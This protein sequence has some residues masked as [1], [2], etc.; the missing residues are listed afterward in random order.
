FRKR[1]N[2]SAVNRYSS[3]QFILFEQRH[4]EVRPYPFL[5]VRFGY[6]ALGVGEHVRN[7]DGP[8]FK[9]YSTQC[10]LSPGW[11][12]RVLY[13]GGQCRGSVIPYYGP[14]ELSIKSEHRAVLR[15]AEADRIVED[16]LKNRLDVGR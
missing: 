10:A 6:N 12:R 16:R 3:D 4:P 8:F 2:L 7:V 11:D 5:P 13:K 15:L 14:K 1:P 9:S